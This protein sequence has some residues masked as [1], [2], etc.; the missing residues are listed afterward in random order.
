MAHNTL[1]SIAVTQFWHDTCLKRIILLNIAYYSYRQIS[2]LYR[3]ESC[4]CTA[5]RWLII[6]ERCEKKHRD[7]HTHTNWGF[8]VQSWIFFSFSY[9]WQLRPRRRELSAK[10]VHWSVEVMLQIALN[11]KNLLSH[12]LY[13]S[14]WKIPADFLLIF[15][16]FYAKIRMKLALDARTMVAL[17]ASFLISGQQNNWI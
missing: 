9:S 5:D 14:A 15:F 17:L 12:C 3:M 8:S 16:V 2:E 11:K 6:E 10:V 4:L 13:A 7:K 1:S